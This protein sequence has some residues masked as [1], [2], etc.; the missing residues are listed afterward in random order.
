M[1]D[2]YIPNPLQPKDPLGKEIY[3]K[4]ELD[5]ISLTT[6]VLSEGG[7]GR[8]AVR[9]ISDT[10]YTLTPD[11]ENTLLIFTANS[12]V[13]ITVPINAAFPPGFLAFTYQ[14]G[15]GPVD[16]VGAPGVDIES[17]ISLTIG[18]QYSAFTLSN[19]GT[20]RWR[21]LGDQEGTGGGGGGGEANTSSNTGAG[22]GLALP[23]VG[24]DLPFKSLTAGANI[25]LTPSGT[26]IEIASAAGGGGEANTSSNQGAGEGL[27]LPKSG[28]DLPFKTIT[29]GSNITLTPGADTLEIST[30]GSG[31]HNQLTNR[32]LADQHPIS[33]ITDLQTTL[34]GK[35]AQGYGGIR[36][37]TPTAIADLAANWETLPANAGQVTTPVGIGQN[38]ATDS[39]QFQ[40][41]G[42]Y[43]V[44][45]N[46]TLSHNE[47]NAGRTMGIRL[48]NVTDAVAGATTGVATGRNTPATTFAYS[49]LVEIGT[50]QLNDDLR[51]EVG[52]SDSY[53]TVQVQDYSYLATRVSGGDV[54]GGG[55][56]SRVLLEEITDPVSGEFDFNN[57][58]QTYKN[59][60]FEAQIRSTGAG[61]VDGTFVYL[62][63]E[64][65]DTNYHSQNMR[66]INGS[67]IFSE[68][69]NAAGG[70]VP[71]AGSPANYY[72][73]TTGMIMDYTGSRVKA[74]RLDPTVPRTASELDVGSFML[75]ASTIT[76]P[77][78]RLRVRT[79]NHPT[80][81]LVGTVR[82]YGI[83]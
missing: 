41:E 42:I 5:K 63:E 45:I 43:L 35:V 29:A 7:F 10:A 15:T 57:I 83:T 33:A 81:T 67:S 6:K 27:A 46:A 14:E 69:N 16:V 31:D 62:N 77:I 65:T 64:T 73:V 19:L 49:F 78:T 39:L 38:F 32:D 75:L 54:V 51:V 24:V 3:L 4:Q 26:E 1:S 12:Q 55:T 59:L 2:V 56:V 11:D 58:D 30:S 22:E 18:N 50:D 34:D 80:D 68:A 20:N 40:S 37:T 28:V 44:T 79:N 25:T 52:G 48:Y 82:L 70:G 61:T 21:I 66:G 17:A 9:Y 23:K 76:V 53:T 60:Y 72:S 71:A 47:S 74:V 8:P 36:L 13:I